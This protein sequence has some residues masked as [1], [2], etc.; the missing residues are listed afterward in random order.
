MTKKEFAD[1]NIGMTFDFI[2]QLLEHPEIVDTIKDGAEVNFIN[3]K[4]RRLKK[5]AGKEEEK[6][7][8]IKS[9]IYLKSYSI[10]SFLSLR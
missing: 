5:R 8:P 1:K 3:L 4:T 9:A 2:K 10:L 6:L 7:C